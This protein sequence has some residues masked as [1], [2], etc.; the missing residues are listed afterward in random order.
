VS[1]STNGYFTGY[2]PKNMFG[3]SAIA[4]CNFYITV[5]RATSI[6]PSDGEVLTTVGSLALDFSGVTIDWF[7]LPIAKTAIKKTAMLY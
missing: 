4:K 6:S 1:I 2:L 5:F 7:I 3:N